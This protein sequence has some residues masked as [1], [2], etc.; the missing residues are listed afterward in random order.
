MKVVAFNGSPRKDGNTAILINHVLRELEN[1]GVEI[2]LVQFSGKTI[3][4][5]IACYKCFENKNRRCA[6]EKD[7]LNEFA[8]VYGYDINKHQPNPNNGEIDVEYL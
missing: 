8:R 7:I 1:Q 3:H 2:E 4:G 5:C 6:V